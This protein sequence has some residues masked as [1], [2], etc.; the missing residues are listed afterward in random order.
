MLFRSHMTVSQWVRQTLRD[1]QREY[2]TTDVDRKIQVVRESVEHSFPAADIQ[3]MLR[4]IEA[5]LTGE[6]GR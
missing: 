4:E 6:A 3:S 1:A 5:G 2:P